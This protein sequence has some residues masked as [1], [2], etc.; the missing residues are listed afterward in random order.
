LLGGIVLS[1]IVWYSNSGGKKNGNKGG[2]N[3]TSDV[4]ALVNKLSS[5][6]LRL[7]DDNCIE[8]ED[9]IDA[10]CNLDTCCLELLADSKVVG[11]II[12]NWGVPKYTRGVAV[13]LVSI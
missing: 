7:T 10:I 5:Y 4:V 12:F 1:V 8:Q 2:R 13:D 9:V 3:M 11:F 6:T